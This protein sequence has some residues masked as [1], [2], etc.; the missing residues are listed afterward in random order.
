MKAG[1]NMSHY[2]PIDKD[3]VLATN[4]Q[5]GTS[6]GNVPG[7]AQYSLGGFNGIRGYRQFTD[8]GLGSNMIIA[9]A[10]LRHTLIPKSDNKF[11]NAIHKNVKIGLFGDAGQVSGSTTYNNLL[12]RNSQAGSVE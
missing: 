3:T 11:L 9:R 6:M 4:F 7:F 5:A 12:T 8:L 1:V 10:E 2:T